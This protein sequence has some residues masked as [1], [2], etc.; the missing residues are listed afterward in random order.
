MITEEAKQYLEYTLK[1][2]FTGI[3]P[4]E[5]GRRIIENL[6][7]KT[8]Q[9]QDDIDSRIDGTYQ[10]LEKLHKAETQRDELLKIYKE[11]LWAGVQKK[12]GNSTVISLKNVLQVIEEIEVKEL[13]VT[14]CP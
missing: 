2:D 13:G 6:I 9:Q 5:K 7:I 4:S 8:E 10:I 14:L 11:T 12:A 1:K 3:R